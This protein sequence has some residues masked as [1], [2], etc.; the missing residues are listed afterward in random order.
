MTDEEWAKFL[1]EKADNDTENGCEDLKRECGYIAYE[2]TKLIN[3]YNERQK[4]IVEH[5]WSY[6][7]HSKVVERTLKKFKV[8]TIWR[9][10][11]AHE[12][13][14]TLMRKKC[15]MKPNCLEDVQKDEVVNYINAVAS[16]DD[17]SKI[18]YYKYVA[19][20]ILKN[21]ITI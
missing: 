1:R 2:I 3:E 21:D 16:E 19:E 12:Y 7:W 18:F 5:K 20:R 9:S 6:W 11:K 14:N 17:L 15:K 8:K 13:Y 10:K 4:Y